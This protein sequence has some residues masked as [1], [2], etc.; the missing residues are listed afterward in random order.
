MT[1]TRR[2]MLQFFVGASLGLGGGS[3]GNGAFAQQDPIDA[4]VRRTLASYF[5]TL[6]P[7]DPQAPGAVTAGI[8]ARFVSAAQA[9]AQVRKLFVE[10]CRWLDSEAQK[11]GARTFPELGE[12]GRNTI[13]DR[14]SRSDL[15]SGPRRFFDQTRSLAFFIYYG[16]A[17][18]WPA[19]GY[20]GPPQPHGFP[21]YA[22][23]PA[24]SR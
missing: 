17:L 16:T 24:I 4:A 20:A 6:I 7:D 9:S 21:D 11:L 15:Q 10:G 22:T 13:V 1:I 19:I 5:D 14:A 18:G 8:D 23:S 12:A 2:V 3:K